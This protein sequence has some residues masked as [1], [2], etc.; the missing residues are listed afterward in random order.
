MGILIDALAASG[1]SLQIAHRNAFAALFVLQLAA[2][3]WLLIG[4]R[5][6]APEPLNPTR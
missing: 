2:S 4:G 5:R 3:A 6:P 1:Q